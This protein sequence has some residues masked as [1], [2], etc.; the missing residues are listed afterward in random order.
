[1]KKIFLD[2]GTHLG[3]GILEIS[4]HEN[5]NNT[6]EVFTW[7]ANPY[8]FN[9]FPAQRFTHLPNLTRFH[10]AVSDVDGT[11]GMNIHSVE[12]NNLKNIGMGSSILNLNEWNSV[13]GMHG[14]SFTEV[15]QVESIDFSNWIK[16]HCSES[17]F[18]VLKLDIEG[19]EYR[20]L[21]K[22][23]AD[24]TLKYINSLYVEWH[25]AAFQNKEP[26]LV[27]YNDIINKVKELNIKYTRWH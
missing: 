15:K 12:Q 4:Q 25:F 23:I 20:V 27:K 18:I 2:C 9:Q 17:D 19:A 21:E 6:W 11:I 8:A 26:Y 16:T 5:I 14:G 22:M 13:P 3:Q 1:M 10:Q 24:D 7:E